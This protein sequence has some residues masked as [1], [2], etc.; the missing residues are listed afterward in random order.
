MPKRRRRESFDT[1]ATLEAVRDTIEEQGQ[2]AR[3]LF[4]AVVAALRGE[5]PDEDLD[6]DLDELQEDF[7]E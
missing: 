2:I 7:E 6:E 5:R 4:R 1:E 3:V